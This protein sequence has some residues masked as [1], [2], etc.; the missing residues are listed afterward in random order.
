LVGRLLH[1]VPISDGGTGSGPL[2][3]VVVVVGSAV[4]GV[5]TVAF[6]AGKVV[7]ERAAW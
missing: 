5:V 1:C 3:G 4:V 6:V 7:L 2:A